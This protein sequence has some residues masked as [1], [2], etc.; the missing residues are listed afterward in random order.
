MVQIRLF[1]VRILPIYRYAVY[2]PFETDYMISTDNGEG[3]D[4]L[5]IYLTLKAYRHHTKP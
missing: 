5:S 1:S 2:C 4:I 3:M